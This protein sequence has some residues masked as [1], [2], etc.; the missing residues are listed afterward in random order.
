MSRLLGIGVCQ[1]NTDVTSIQQNMESLASQIGIMRAYPEV[2]RD[3]TC[4]GAQVI[5]VPTYT[6]T[7]DRS[8]EIIL[9]RAAA[10]CNQCYM[11]SVN[12]L[13]R[14]SKGQSLIADPEGNVMQLAGQQPE[15]LMAM[16]DLRRVDQIRKYG[17]CGVS[18][19][20]AS[21]I[22][23]SHSFPHQRPDS[24]TSLS[25]QLEGIFKK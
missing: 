15:N 5:L 6:S 20:L 8:Q 11:V 4:K 12:A 3:L 17:T 13:G 10:I 18:R 16:L 21:Y 24:K 23:E 22:H 2:I 25:I 14:G 19:P 9:C 1:L 7:Q